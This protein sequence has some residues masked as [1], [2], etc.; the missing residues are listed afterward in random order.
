MPPK[1]DL[2][3]AGAVI[4]LERHVASA[5]GVSKFHE[6]I[7]TVIAPHSHMPKYA[8]KAK[9]IMHNGKQIGFVA[10]LPGPMK[11]YT[12]KKHAAFDIAGNKVAH[13]DSPEEAHAHLT[14]EPVSAFSSGTVKVIKP[15]FTP[16][17][18]TTIPAAAVPGTPK[19]SWT[20]TL[21]KTPTRDFKQS[22][23]HAVTRQLQKTRMSE[24]QRYAWGRYTD[25]QYHGMNKVAH[26]QSGKLH[27]MYSDE[28]LKKQVKNL[29]EAFDTVGFKTEQ[30]ETVYR[31]TGSHAYFAKVGD[32]VS[33]RG[34]TSTSVLHQSSKTFASHN[35]VLNIKLP[36]G[37]KYLLGTEYEREII[38]PPGLKMRVLAV[39][40][41][42]R[43]THLEVLPS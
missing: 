10:A 3:R 29:T 20:P 11:K 18:K 1:I 42:G 43:T 40:S 14:G 37:Q 13:V 22:P 5:A 36:P 2:A 27:S 19:H 4:D 24:P 7:G 12:G 21:S 6:P 39:D 23:E 25:G 9:P 34:F 35:P 26:G 15:K 38:L 32:N 30:T 16:K 33:T 8:Q 31:G 28:E 17:P 41:Q